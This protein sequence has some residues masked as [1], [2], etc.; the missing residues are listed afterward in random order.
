M[1]EQSIRTASA[2]AYEL[3]E[4]PRVDPRT[5]ELLWV[6]VH[7]GRLHVGSY[8][9]SA[10]RTRAT[11]ELGG[12]VSAVAPAVPDEGWLLATSRGL[13]HLGPHGRRLIGEVRGLLNDG[14]RDGR[15]RFWVGTISPPEVPYSGV[16]YRLD[17]DGG[18]HEM[19]RGIGASNGIG[20]S[21]DGRWMYLVDSHAKR[22]DVI[23]FDIE[24]GALGRRQVFH[25][26]E[27]GTPDGL[28]VAARGDV[29]VAVWDGWR[30]DR[31]SPDGR[32]IRSYRVPTARP[33]ACC[34][35]DPTTVLVTSAYWGLDRTE[36]PDAGRIFVLTFR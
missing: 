36:D 1:A 22:V 12:R 23:E 16:L 7:V 25:R 9:G 35:L 28:A 29:W 8:D 34:L 24:S 31:F 18:V 27:Q 13:E 4:C 26:Y 5:G 20:W 32:L 15:G 10:V 14:V 11:Y 19:L 21:P 3:G 33:T 2:A 17:P 30:V 6:D